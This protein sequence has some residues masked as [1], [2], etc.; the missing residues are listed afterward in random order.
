[1][2][3]GANHREAVQDYV[4]GRMS[5]IDRRVFEERL[6]GDASLVR[7]L[8]GLLRLR[9]G[10]EILRERKVI[11]EL[12]RP[13][14][15]SS[16]RRFALASAAAVVVVAMCIGLYQV[17]RSPPVVAASIAALSSDAVLPVVE[18]YSFAAMRG[19]AS[20]PVLLLPTSGALEL[21][22][23]TP[24]ADGHRT[25]RVTLSEVRSQRSSPIGLAEHLAPDAD[26]FI[27]FYA[28]AGKLQPGEYSLSVAPDDV[29]DK[30]DAT[31]FAFILTR[32]TAGGMP[33]GT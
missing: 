24:V 19:G 17:R 10:L 32:P 2:S 18:H 13:Q 25:F 12:T 4:A 5:D 27:V 8:E 30:S 9:E 23:L 11:E 6:L 26:G 3:A 7:D 14:R 15:S 31:N 33:N 20:K 21:R 29:Q 28:A 1:M 16:L 22:A